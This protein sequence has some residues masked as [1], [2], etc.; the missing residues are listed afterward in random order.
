MDFEIRK[1]I[2]DKQIDQLI[3]YS[4]N[5]ESVGKFTSDRER[6]KNRQAF[7]EWQQ[8]GRE[9]F[10]L[11]NKNNDLV[12]IVWTG[13]KELPEADWTEKFETNK[14]KL[15]FSIRIYGEARGKGLGVD[16]MRKCIGDKKDIWLATSNDNIAAK[17][18]YERFGFRQVSKPSDKDKIVMIY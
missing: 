8:K 5:D 9:I 11:N 10:T 1:G 16:F 18:I 14:Y 13:L 4:L 17:K 6:F 7:E 12:G 3:E 2:L 15:S